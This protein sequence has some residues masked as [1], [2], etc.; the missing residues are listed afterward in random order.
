MSFQGVGMNNAELLSLAGLEVCMSSINNNKKLHFASQCFV[1]LE[2][3][4][5]VL[6]L[7]LAS[8]FFNLFFSSSIMES[9]VEQIP[10]LLETYYMYT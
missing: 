6:I 1:A 8:I 9:T 7:V 10:T 3:N 5:S 4:S 2:S